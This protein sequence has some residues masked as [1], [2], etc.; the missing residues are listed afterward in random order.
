M[1]CKEDLLN[2]SCNIILEVICFMSVFK[3]LSGMQ[4]YDNPMDVLAM[5][6][7]VMILVLYS[8]KNFLSGLVVVELLLRLREKIKVKLC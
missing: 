8:T 2:D 3:L 1:K 6:F 4:I 5:G 7:S